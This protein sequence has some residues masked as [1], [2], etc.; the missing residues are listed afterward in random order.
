M[1]TNKILFNSNEKIKKFYP[2]NTTTN[3]FIIVT[4]SSVYKLCGTAKYEGKDCY[5][6]QSLIADNAY[7]QIRP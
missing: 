1:S 4:Q 3:E 6:V 2:S 7:I 5:V